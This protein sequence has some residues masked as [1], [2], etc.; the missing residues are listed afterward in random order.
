MVREMASVTLFRM[1]NEFRTC[2]EGQAYFH[3]N[4]GFFIS[5]AK[6]IDLI[7]YALDDQ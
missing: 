5:N 7:P 6:K 4:L 2:A 1:N 3:S